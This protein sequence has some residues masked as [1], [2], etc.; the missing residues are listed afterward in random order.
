MRKATDIIAKNQYVIPS[1]F[2]SGTVVA[3]PRKDGETD[4][5]YRD[6]CRLEPFCM[7]IAMNDAL[8][9]QYVNIEYIPPSSVTYHDTSEQ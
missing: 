6:R 4:K 3:I 7:G 5:Q 8:P 2:R 9:S 1:R